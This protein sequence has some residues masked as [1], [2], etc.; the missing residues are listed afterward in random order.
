MSINFKFMVI[1]SKI[2][3]NLAILIWVI[4]ALMQTTC[5]GGGGSSSI[6]GQ[7]P[8]APKEIIVKPGNGEVLIKWNDISNA[9]SYNIYYS[10]TPKVT[11]IS[12]T[13]ITNVKSPFSHIKLTNGITYYYVITAVNSIGESPE[14]ELVSATPSETITN[15]YVGATINDYLAKRIWDIW[16]RFDPLPALHKNGFGWARVWVRTTSSNDLKNTPSSQWYTLPWK[17]E[18]WSS[19]EYAEQ[20]FK[21]ASKEGMRLNLVFFLS[22]KPAAAFYQPAPPEWEGLNVEESAIALEDYCYRT[23]KYFKDKGLNIEIYDIG[24]EIEYGILNFLPGQR[25]TLPPGIDITTDMEWMKNNIWN[26][27]AILLKGAIRGVKKA[28][29]DAKITL[30]INTLGFRPENYIVKS[31]FKT[32]IDYGVEFDYAGLSFPYFN[33]YPVP[34]P[35]FN[36]SQLREVI[37]YI[38]S[39]GK[40][41]IISEFNYPNNPNG[42]TGIPDP[43]YPFTLEGQAKWV[44]DFLSFF[45]NNDN[46]TG[47]F[48]F[49]ADYFPGMNRGSIP[50]LESCGLF[51]NETQIVPALLEFNLN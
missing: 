31:F 15:K 11:K 5:G 40:K 32:M 21:E 44:K 48:Y 7:A 2:K 50:E 13:K 8:N 22:D 45:Q 3:K 10:T 9:I 20:I 36:S 49:D 38:S 27:E 41:V 37:N 42:I 23:S 47:I 24:N 43:A 12:G 17:D 29:P 46:I 25:V 16:K 39:L 26:I 28:D 30:H 51:A 19:L 33:F 6:S 1:V 35:Y 18:Y 34:Q 14:S 4:L